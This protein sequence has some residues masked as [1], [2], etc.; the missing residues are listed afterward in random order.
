MPLPVLIKPP[1]P[2]GK[3]YW[4]SVG[5]TPGVEEGKPGVQRYSGSGEYAGVLVLLLAA[6]A[7][8]VA[9]SRKD[10][11]LGGDEK[12]TV[13]FWCCAAGISLL[14]AYG[15]HFYAYRLVFE[16]PFYT[17]IRNPIK[18]MH[19][20]Q[21]SVLMMFGYGLLSIS[22]AYLSDCQRCIAWNRVYRSTQLWVYSAYAL[23]AVSILGW[24]VF[25]AMGAQVVRYMQS[26]GF[27]REAA[28]MAFKASFTE[29]G[30][31]VLMLIASIVL[32]INVFRK[33]FKPV[34]AVLLL[35]L[36]LTADLVRSNAPWVVVYNYKEKLAE[37]QI[38]KTLS[39]LTDYRTGVL[40]FSGIPDL[41]W[42]Q[43]YYNVE[44]LQNK[45]PYYG[46]RSIDVAQEPRRGQDKVDF[47]K[48]LRSNMLRYW[49]LT[50]TRVFYGLAGMTD[51]LNKLDPGSTPA[52]TETTR[53][54]I[55][56]DGNKI[57]QVPDANGHFALIE[58]AKAIPRVCLYGRWTVARTSEEAL[59]VIA[60]PFFDPQTDVVVQEELPRAIGNA[61]PVSAATVEMC[62]RGTT[63]L[64]VR[65]A[66]SSGS[67]LFINDRYD[68]DWT[69]KVDEKPAKLLRCNYIARGVYLSPGK[70]YVEFRYKPSTL[71]LKISLACMGLCLLV[72]IK[73]RKKL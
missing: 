55:T 41:A 62:S 59:S 73:Y 71:P 40:A 65:T 58:Y 42:L 31:Y 12:K 60:S 14:L 45:F 38:L 61:E 51:S 19:P 44:L 32:L 39:W 6:Y 54:N 22:R 52:F 20:F 33:M 64:T 63:G 36:L 29:I 21:L 28:G 27:E 23:T 43:Q 53:F 9:F 72:L 26:V 18:Y 8:V 1:S 50:S 17:S 48:A 37:D 34:N 16:I 13:I 69:V 10:A 57:L 24:L 25:S 35:A 68:A 4:G 30:L 3:A 2:D 67:V 11:S 66:Y 5:Q 46:I 47:Q 15:R 70:H 7:L 49:Q 56:K